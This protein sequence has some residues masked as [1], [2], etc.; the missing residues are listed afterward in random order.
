MIVC[1]D[2]LQCDTVLVIHHTDCGAHAALYHPTAVAEHAK[3]KAD[4]ALGT[5][6]GGEP[7]AAAAISCT[8]LR[9][10]AGDFGSELE[11]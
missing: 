4:Q 6:L 2:V 5:H 11:A 9:G 3:A 8:A 1:Q 10:L 7:G